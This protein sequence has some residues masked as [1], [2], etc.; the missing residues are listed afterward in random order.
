MCE[1]GRPI[2]RRDMQVNS[3]KYV[4]YQAGNVIYPSA[5]DA[6]TSLQLL[7]RY[8][9]VGYL[10]E[11]GFKT[12][13]KVV[14]VFLPRLYHP[15]NAE[16]ACSTMFK[17][18]LYGGSFRNSVLGAGTGGFLCAGAPSYMKMTSSSGSRLRRVCVRYQ[19]S[20]VSL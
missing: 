6:R 13:P 19:Q 16:F 2:K 15:S 1:P 20:V 18:G 3:T 7:C 10:G 5:M 11:D 8:F 17:N 9:T 4:G 14:V 12:L